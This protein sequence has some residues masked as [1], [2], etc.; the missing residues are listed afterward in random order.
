MGKSLVSCFFRHSVLADSA[1]NPDKP[2]IFENP[3]GRP[4]KGQ[5]RKRVLETRT[6]GNPNIFGDILSFQFL[7]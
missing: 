1:K 2:P 3:P 5:K 7:G 6:Y 4:D